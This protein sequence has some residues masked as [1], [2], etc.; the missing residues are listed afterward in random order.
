MGKQWSSIIIA[1]LLIGVAF[2]ASYDFY[3]ILYKLVYM[4]P[5]GWVA[6]SILLR[7]IIAVALSRAFYLLAQLIGQKKSFLVNVF[8][9]LGG[10]I[11]GVGISFITPIYTTDYAKRYSE[12]TLDLNTLNKH[13]DT[14]IPLN[15]QAAVIIFF[16]EDCS[17]CQF[18]SE[19]LGMMASMGN[20]PP[21]HAI[22]KDSY[23]RINQFLTE[24]N[25]LYFYPHQLNNIEMFVKLSDA[26]LPSLFLVDKNGN[27]TM[28]WYGE[29]S[30][31]A[32]DEIIQ[33][34][35]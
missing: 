23:E 21:I 3:S 35:K 14:P 16:S 8:I 1:I 2:Y 20:T 26:R 17:H 6:S 30:Y 18:T 19:Q 27:T 10:F 11:L 28:H 15:N 34:A 5:L 9:S 31:F 12:A 33:S 24:H 25:G 22:F 32:M 7:I 13:I 29:L 4:F